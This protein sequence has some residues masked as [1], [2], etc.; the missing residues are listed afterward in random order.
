MSPGHSAKECAKTTTITV[1]ELP[2]CKP[3]NR[4]MNST[5]D[6]PTYNPVLPTNTRNQLQVIPVNLFGENNEKVECY[7]ILDNGSPTSY[8]IGTT[9]SCIN[10]PKAIQ[11]G[12]NVMH[13]FNQSTINANLVRPDFGRY[14]DS[15]PLFGLSYVHSINYWKLSD[16][17][18]QELNENLLNLLSFAA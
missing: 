10:A 1:V 6:A 7:A 2:L 16:A 4:K 3:L 11:F 12:L 14:N 13:D 15:E 17:P 18:V 8:V 9:A 5:V